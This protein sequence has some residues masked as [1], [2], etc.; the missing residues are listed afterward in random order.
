[1]RHNS[2]EQNYI[3][4]CMYGKERSVELQSLAKNNQLHA[5]LLVGGLVT[6]Q[7]FLSNIHSM[8]VE[9]KEK[10]EQAYQTFEIWIREYLRDNLILALPML[11]QSITSFEE[12]YFLELVNEYVGNRNEE[13]LVKPNEPQD[14]PIFVLS[15]NDW[16]F[17]TIAAIVPFLQAIGTV[18][19]ISFERA[20]VLLEL[21][22][23]EEFTQLVANS[24]V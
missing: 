7:Y 10:Q 24:V 9:E 3:F 14:R 8:F 13:G 23:T 4:A 18:T 15:I 21:E 17:K 2:K 5:E 12:S 22:K 20:F 19:L 16:E 6:L 11:Q 1:M